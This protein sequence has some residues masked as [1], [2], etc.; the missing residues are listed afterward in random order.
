MQDTTPRSPATRRFPLAFVVGCALL[1]LISVGFGIVQFRVNDFSADYR[2]YYAAGYLMRTHPAALYDFQSQVTLMDSLGNNRHHLTLYLHPPFEALFFA[3]FAML[4][5]HASYYAFISFSTLLLIATF[6]LA[7][8]LFDQYIPWMQAKPGFLLVLFGPL[9]YSLLWGQD[10][11]L[12][13]FLCCLAWS[14][15][16]RDKD[17]A[18]GVALGLALFRYPLALPITIIFC[19]RRGRRFITGFVLTATALVLLSLLLIGPSAFSAM[20]HMLAEAALLNDQSVQAKIHMGIAPRIMPN[21]VG[22]LYVAGTRLLSAHAAFVVVIVASTLLFV[23]TTW[24][25]VRARS[26]DV[27]LAMA[28]LLSV[29]TSY[30]F[31]VYDLTL[32]ILPLALLARRLSWRVLLVFYVLPL[33]IPIF[34]NWGWYFLDAIPTLL[35]LLY[36]GTRFADSDDPR[37]LTA[38]PI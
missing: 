21:L 34:L 14:L 10:S 6:F 33:L 13:L 27:A 36:T 4:P 38:D 15:L 32:L 12:F 25:A 9:F 5:Y 22:L 37:P 24:K 23:W 16:S 20:N 8:P 31:Y 2:V 17:A 35:L 1:L 3:L 30:H 19:L 11:I 18:A 7:R 28:V 26:L 29:L